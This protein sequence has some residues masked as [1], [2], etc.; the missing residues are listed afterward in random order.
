ME[1]AQALRSGIWRSGP[2]TAL[3]YGSLGLHAVL[4]LATTLA[5][6]SWRLPPW[7]LLQ[8]GLG[9][10]IPVL[11]A[12]H[13]AAARG[14]AE[15][16]GRDTRYRFVL[17]GLWPDAAVAQTLFLVAVWTHGVIGLRLWLREKP[18]YPRW[19][20]LLLALALLVPALASAGWIEAAR[21]LPLEA[22]DVGSP[23]LD[24]KS[25]V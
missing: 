20:P 6:R 8:V 17:D 18:W 25:V 5:R 15:W 4:G 14:L 13:V 2:G 23:P 16:V 12:A 1:A 22:G 11:G 21:R 3:L 7:Q 9:L 10:A 24:R 19:A